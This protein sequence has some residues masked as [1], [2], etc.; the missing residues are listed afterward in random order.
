M[1][2]IQSLI[3]PNHC[4]LYIFNGSH[5]EVDNTILEKTYFC[6]KNSWEHVFKYEMNQDHKIFSDD[7]TRQDEIVTL[8]YKNNCIGVA[9][10]RK[11]DLS[12]ITIREDSCFRFWPS[13]ELDKLMKISSQITIAS[14]FTISSEFRS[15]TL[16]VCWKT[17][18]LSLYVENF[19]HSESDLMVT[20]ARKMKSNEK[21]CYLL[22]AKPLVTSIPYKTH[23]SKTVGNESVDI[24]FWDKNK[25]SQV[26]SEVE[27]FKNIVWKNKINTSFHTRK[28]V[29]NAS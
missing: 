13:D 1:T 23:D 20:A 10:K 22:G 9:F 17:L 25:T 12:L 18:F 14:Y 27:N 21:L 11:V 16:G 26:E 24:L 5:P 4:Q 7:F 8:F 19:I 29:Q 28:G 3:N 2:N 6:W 15:K